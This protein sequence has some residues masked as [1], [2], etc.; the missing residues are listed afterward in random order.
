MT[1]NEVRIVPEEGI[2]NQRTGVLTVEHVADEEPPR[3]EA[4][5]RESVTRTPARA[6]EADPALE[7]PRKSDARRARF[8]FQGYTPA[9]GRIWQRVR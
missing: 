1:E 9:G 8:V 5:I 3:T 7:Y 2:L 4:S 6:G